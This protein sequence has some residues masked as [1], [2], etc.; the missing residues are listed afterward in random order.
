MKKNLCQKINIW[1]GFAALSIL[2]VNH[3]CLDKPKNKIRGCSGKYVLCGDFNMVTNYWEE[4]KQENPDKFAH[5]LPIPGSSHM[6]I[7]AKYW[8]LLV[9]AG[10]ISEG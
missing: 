1:D 4:V 7:S 6:E 8:G 10:L 9:E 3:I 2:S 5:I